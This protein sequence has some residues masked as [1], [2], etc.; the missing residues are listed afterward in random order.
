M[1]DPR[2]IA[3]ASMNRLIR[4]VSGEAFWAVFDSE[5]GVVASAKGCCVVGGEEVEANTSRVHRP[6]NLEDFL[7]I[8]PEDDTAEAEF[9][10]IGQV[11]RFIELGVFHEDRKSVV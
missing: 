3:S 10:I 2:P 5:A 8:A 11:D 1:E 9:S 4:Q 7:L 6:G